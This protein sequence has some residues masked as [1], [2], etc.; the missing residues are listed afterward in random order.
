MDVHG[1]AR[2]VLERLGNELRIA[3]VPERG[4]ADR[5]LEQEHLIGEMDGVAMQEIDLKLRGTAFLDDRVDLQILPLGK[6]V[7]VVHDLL[8]LVYGTEAVSLTARAWPARAADRR[9][10]RIVGVWVRLGEIEFELGRHHRHPAL[11]RIEAEHPL[12]DIARGDLGRVA[13]LPG[14]VVD[15][16][17]R[18]TAGPR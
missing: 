14:R 5:P 16:L 12:Q 8:V 4:L 6:L 11:L 18:R 3:A 7:D 15:D 17:S 10:E 2:L 13:A 9:L 1:A